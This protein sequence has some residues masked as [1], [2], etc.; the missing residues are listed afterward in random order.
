MQ[1]CQRELKPG[2][3]RNMDALFSGTEWR[4]RINGETQIIRAHQAADLLREKINANWCTPFFMRFG[5]EA[6]RYVLLHFTQSDRG[7]DLMKDTMWKA[8][9]SGGFFV[10]KS[11][12]VSQGLLP[13]EEKPDLSPVEEWVIDALSKGPKR[14][15]NLTS[16]FLAQSWRD[17]HLNQ[18]IR[19]LVREGILSHEGKL[20]K[21]ANPLLSL[22]QERG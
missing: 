12:D 20:A 4:T 18:T 14:W 1:L 11:F 22:K 5:P 2:V 21:T 13:L 15:D 6:I 19:R 8:C 3:A 7:R 9:P 16:D 10:R 17:T